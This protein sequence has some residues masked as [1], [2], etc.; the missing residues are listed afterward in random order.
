VDC[1]ATPAGVASRITFNIPLE[2]P[3]HEGGA[4]LTK[5]RKQISTALI[6]EFYDYGKNAQATIH[7]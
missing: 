1:F 3:F 5:N 4:N 2:E 6:L 7:A